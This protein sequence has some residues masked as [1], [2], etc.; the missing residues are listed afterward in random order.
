[1]AIPCIVVAIVW[2]TSIDSKATTAKEQLDGVR[3]MLSDVRERII[4]IEEKI[5]SIHREE[6]K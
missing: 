6:R 5:K 4:R 3:E 1:M 2:L